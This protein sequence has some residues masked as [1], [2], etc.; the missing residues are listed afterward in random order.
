M[1]EGNWGTY[2]DSEW[3]GEERGRGKE[4]RVYN[5]IIAYTMAIMYLSRNSFPCNRHHRDTCTS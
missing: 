2:V 1:R 4:G 3:R 5:H